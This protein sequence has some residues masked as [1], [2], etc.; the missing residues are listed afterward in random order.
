MLTFIYKGIKKQGSYL[1]V[2]RKED[3]SRVP[4]NLIITLGPLELVMIIDLANQ[5]KLAQANISQVIIALQEDGF[6]LQMASES[7]YL[8]LSTQMPISHSIPKLF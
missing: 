2:E 8:A 7:D 3:F 4:N 5:K 1:Y 6:Y